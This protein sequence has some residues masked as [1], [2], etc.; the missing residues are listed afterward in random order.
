[1]AS[2]L[3]SARTSLRNLRT[4]MKESQRRV[5]SGSL[6]N[7]A[8]WGGAYLG[9]RFTAG[10]MIPGTPIPL[11]TSLGL[12]GVVADLV[13]WSD[14]YILVG[15][16]SSLFKGLALSDSTFLGFKHKVAP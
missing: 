7:A 9:G 6:D 15:A 8:L 11:N 14:D 10:I 4:N 3:D 12:I 1:M 2:K 13:G 5:L 16:L